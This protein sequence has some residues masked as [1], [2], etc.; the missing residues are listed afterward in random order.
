MRELSDK[1]VV[2]EARV[3]LQLWFA[4]EEE[5]EKLHAKLEAMASQI[6]DLEQ[7]MAA[8]CPRCGEVP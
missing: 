4:A 8:P 5:C 6:V 3:L 7:A 1:E 2:R